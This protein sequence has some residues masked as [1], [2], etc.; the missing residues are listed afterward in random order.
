M[1]LEDEP[2]EST[3]L[4]LND[5]AN[6]HCACQDNGC[7]KAEGE[8]HLVRDELHGT[9]HSRNHRVLVVGTPTCHKDTHDANARDSR[10]EE[11]ANVE[12]EHLG[13][14]V[15]RQERECAYRGDNHE[16]RSNIVEHLVGAVD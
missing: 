15:P 11:Y 8:R 16:E 1:A 5:T 12:V 3:S 7:D 10:H 9:T 4:S 14:I 2:A 6:L 13:T